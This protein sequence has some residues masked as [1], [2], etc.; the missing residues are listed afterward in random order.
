[1][2]GVDVYSCYCTE[3]LMKIVIEDIGPDLVGTDLADWAA[4]AVG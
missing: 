2:G 3:E 4:V 1:M